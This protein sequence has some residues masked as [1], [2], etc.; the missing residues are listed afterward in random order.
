M[1]ALITGAGGQVGRELVELARA[2][3]WDVR[4]ADRAALDVTDASAVQA[5]VTAFGPDVVI[6]AAAYTAVDRAEEEREVAFAVNAEAPGHL[7]RA[8]QDAGTAL[9][10][11]STD[12]V[13]DGR[14]GRALRPDDAPAP[15]NAYGCSKLAGER[16]V[17]GLPG[18]AGAVL[19]TSWVYSAH[20]RNFVTNMLARLRAGEALEVVDDQF[21][22]PT[23]AHDLAQLMWRMRGDWVPGVH[24]WCDAG[25]TTW[26]E[27]A[28][29]TRDE[30]LASRQLEA[31]VAITPVSSARRAAPA[32]RP[33]YTPLDTTDTAS[34]FGLTPAPWRE[35]LSRM[36]EEL[37]DPPVGAAE[38]GNG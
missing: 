30:A 20:G 16:A 23:W 26:Y 22:S 10:H 8:C 2:R 33:L 29:A 32:P 11:V 15:I 17:L 1:K 31:P 19:R 36:F 6:N 38:R 3:A 13:F 5:A 9:V 35:N 37:S 4:A 25:I 24:H 34:R 12:Y 18:G 21:G 28:C 27:L 14:A 7:A